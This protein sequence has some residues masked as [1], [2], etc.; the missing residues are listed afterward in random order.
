MCC[1]PGT[2]EGENA[3]K[4][5]RYCNCSIM[6]THKYSCHPSHLSWNGSFFFSSVVPYANVQKGSISIYILLFLF[7]AY[8]IHPVHM[9]ILVHQP[10]GHF[11]A[12]R[13]KFHVTSEW[14]LS[15]FEKWDKTTNREGGGANTDMKNLYY[16][17]S[18][19]GK[20]FRLNEYGRLRNT[21]FFYVCGVQWNSNKKGRKECAGNRGIKYKS[22]RPWWLTAC[23]AVNMV[24]FFIGHMLLSTI[25]QTDMVSCSYTGCLGIELINE[26]FWGAEMQALIVSY[27]IYL[28]QLN[29]AQKEPM[30]SHPFLDRPWQVIVTDLFKWNNRDYI[31]IAKYCGR[32]F[33]WEKK[34]TCL[35]INTVIHKSYACQVWN[36]TETN[37]QRWTLV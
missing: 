9:T 11:V 30:I 14:F 24:C 3:V 37:Q 20:R 31:P 33:G 17:Q 1:L 36:T 34:I 15:S 4:K 22:I 10:H 23:L 28:K 29:S 2:P 27:N 18:W 13:R 16:F 5:M 8:V 26:L 25:E 32:Y 6:I 21:I 12:K 7:I 19:L 35:T